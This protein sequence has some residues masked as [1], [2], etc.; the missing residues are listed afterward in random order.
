MPVPDTQ[1]M[2]RFRPNAKLK[3][4]LIKRPPAIAIQHS[5]N[6]PLNESKDRIDKMKSFFYFLTIDGTCLKD[7]GPLSF[8]GEDREPG[9][10]VSVFN[11]VL[12]I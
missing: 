4:I 7:L 11:E 5:L 2:Q 9:T 6:R 10:V 3:R 1:E 8:L 12:L